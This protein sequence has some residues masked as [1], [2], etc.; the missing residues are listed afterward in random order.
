MLHLDNRLYRTVGLGSKDEYIFSS[1]DIKYD[2]WLNIGDLVD[3]KLIQEDNLCSLKN[4]RILQLNFNELTL[5]KLWLFIFEKYPEISRKAPN[6]LFTI[7]N[8]MSL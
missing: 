5:N 1:I 3:S 7:I 8:F 6:T 4:D 2:D